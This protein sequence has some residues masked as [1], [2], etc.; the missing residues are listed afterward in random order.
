M[1]TFAALLAVALASG[2]AAQP[3]PP[4]FSSAEPSL[5][6]AFEEMVT[7]GAAIAPGK[8]GRGGR[9]MIPITGGTFE[10]PGIRGT[11]LPGGWDWQLQRVDGCGEVEADY[12]LKTDDGV[13]INI[14]NRGAICPPAAGTPFTVRTH[15]LFEAPIGK[16]DWLNKSAF[17]GTLEPTKAPDGGPAVKIRIYRV[18]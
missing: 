2:A 12:F 13:V 11:I 3:Q 18:R 6:F 9:T 8:T 5:E 7:L 15:P 14:L 16:Y 10:G 17:I 4:A 1:K